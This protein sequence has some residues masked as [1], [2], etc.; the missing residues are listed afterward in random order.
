MFAKLIIDIANSNVDRLFTYA[1]PDELDV[2]AGHRV[3]VPFGRSNKPKEGFVI[4]VCPEYDTG[5]EVKS[6]IKT[7]EPYT[8][9]LPD[10]IELAKWISKAYHCTLCDALRLM[11]PSQ[12][13][14]SRVKEKTVRTVCAAPGIDRE[15]VRS[16]F[17]K[18]DGTAR[19]PKQLEV[20]DLL[21]DSGTSMSVE[22]LSAYIP[23]ASA[24]VSALLKKGCIVEKDFVT[25]RSPFANEI[26]PDV[27]PELTKAQ[28]SALEAVKNGREG[29]VFLLHG[30]TG[31]GKTEVYLNAIKAVLEAGG[32]AIV[33]VPEISLTPQTTDRFRSRFG[34]TVAVMHSHLSMGERYDEWRRI[35]LGK[36]RVVVGARSAVFAPVENLKLIIIDEEHEPSYR[37][38]S[39]PTYS[40]DEVAVRRVRLT[41]G[42]LILGSATPQLI[43]YLRA[44]QGAYKLLELPERINGIPMPEV[45]IVDMRSEFM[46]GNTSIF[47]KDLERKLK[48]CIGG[49]EQAI[50][51]LNRR[52][53]SY[54][55]ECRACGF[56]FKCPHCDVAM[57]YHKF[58]GSLRCHYCGY[59]VR[60]PSV[61][62]SCGSKYIKFSGIGTQQVEEQLKK[63]IPG[64]RCLRM[65]TDTTGGKTSHR[66]ILDSFTRG[67]ADVLIGT[68]MVAK[69]LDIPGVTLV[70]VVFA[71]ASLFHSDYRSGER[72]F[73]LLTQVAGRAGRAVKDGEVKKGKV[74]VQ[75][76]APNHRAVL[77]SAQ[78]NYKGFFDL[79]IKDRLRTL[80]P[81]FAVFARALFECANE[82]A[83]AE[84]AERFAKEAETELKKVL[85]KYDAE[86]EL[87][88]VSYGAAPIRKRDNLYRYAVM[89]KLARTKHTSEAV[90]ALWRLSD[91]FDAEGLRGVEINPNELL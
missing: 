28:L 10:Q 9:L 29:D 41:G 66:D 40:T 61:C 11:L 62:P 82:N 16:T 12:L 47:S 71:D 83:A 23:N 56:V 15:K 14:G 51:F 75:T 79:E 44:K 84:Y 89:L 80:F 30:V 81:P 8:A 57:T 3:L 27:P 52:G 70:G 64:V 26:K 85:S 17:L 87:L 38:E 45:E 88:F 13:R 33:L 7:M 65:D 69:G 32:G 53:Y 36:A 34:E 2:R 4:E 5:F 6:V 58:D 76:N 19:S 48:D 50:L 54:H 55:G 63:L 49:G 78:H 43:S 20:F 72:T 74:V 90:T 73:Q 21:F 42:K 22:D 86:G 18:K 37:S 24:A 35:R 1:V 25:F 68:Q 31:S 39:T 91:G 46:S 59:S 67:E 77:L 60:V